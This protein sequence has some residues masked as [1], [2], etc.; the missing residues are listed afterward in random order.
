MKV[1]GLSIDLSTW[2]SAARL[3]IALGLYY[4]GLEKFAIKLWK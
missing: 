4:L 2:V 3:N 1:F